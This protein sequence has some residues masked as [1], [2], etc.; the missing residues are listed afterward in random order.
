[1]QYYPFDSRNPLY[2]D[3]IGAVAEGQTLRLRLLLHKD[4]KVNAAFM[5]YRNDNSG[6]YRQIEMKPAEML[7]DYQ[8]YDC[9]MNFEAGLYWYFF[10]YESAYGTFF[11]TKCSHSIGFV[12]EDGSPWQQTVYKADFTTPDWLAGGIIYQIFPDRFYNSGK[13]KENL[14]SGRFI[15]KDWDK[16]PEYRQNNGECSLG[17][18]FYGGD[19][20]GIIQKLPYLADL[21]VSCIYLNPIFSSS[22][23]HRYD[24]ADYM[25]IDPLLGNENDLKRLCKEAKK[26]GIS[27]IL[28]GVFSHTGADSVYFNKYGN[29]DSEGAYNSQNSKY[30]SWYKF[31]DWPHKYSAWWGVPSL[32]ET[33]EENP[34]FSD[35]ITGADGVIEHWNKCGIAGWRLDVADEL[36]DDFIVKIR[37]AVKK[38][39][40]EAYLLGEVWEDA[41]NKMSYG[42]RR[43][44]LRGKELDSVM[45][46]PF[47]NAISDFM[48]CGDAV[49]LV[50]TVV[51]ILENYPAP[52]VKVLMNHIGTHDTP[53]ILTRLSKSFKNGESRAWQ[54]TQKLTDE[55]RA[56]AAEKLKLAATLQFT[57]PGVP[58][59]FYGDEAGVEGYGDPFCRAAFPWDSID[60]DLLEFYK[61]L[62]KIRKN[63]SC[64]K[65]GVFIPVHSE[66]GYI[67]YK[68]EDDKDSLLIGVNVNDYDIWAKCPENFTNRPQLLFGTK[69]NSDGY[70][71]LK[72]NS[73][74]IYKIKK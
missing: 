65:E 2:R 27:V 5:L 61:K 64:L 35:Y 33:D 36:P 68:R 28:D 4:A 24:T 73:M 11:V 34:E 8:Y 47:A 55:E 48:Y 21:S 46:Y 51:D 3:R 42:T 67:F 23:N 58:S 54:S 50:D 37:N 30:Y 6:I 62:G 74:C 40:K 60:T 32:P 1:M 20:E 72:P 69:P 57:L 59:I 10:K 29:F 26:Y 43:E 49:K 19:L 38:D 52:A 39:N 22:S 44:F 56:F 66:R 53:R 7:E 41:S 25:K 15:N 12:S 63:A 45:N 70:I 71:N 16:Q 9:E 31:E 13:K 18:D 17:N 14:P